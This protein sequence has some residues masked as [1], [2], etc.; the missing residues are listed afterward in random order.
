MDIKK[1][2]FFRLR[3]LAILHKSYAPVNL[4]NLKIKK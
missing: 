2:G 4:K 1:F 3:T